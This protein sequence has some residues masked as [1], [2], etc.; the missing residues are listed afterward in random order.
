MMTIMKMMV[1]SMK[2]GGGDDDGGVNCMNKT[3]AFSTCKH[4]SCSRR[5]R[6]LQIQDARRYHAGILEF[7]KTNISLQQ[8]FNRQNPFCFFGCC[9]LR[10]DALR[11][12]G[13]RRGGKHEDHILPIQRCWELMS[14]STGI[15]SSNR[16][17]VSVGITGIVQSSSASA[18]H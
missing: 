14:I 2:N 18:P 12:R 5:R 7:R 3:H 4:F 11:W 13:S 16:I 15:S 6:Q 17:G 9:A 8:P 10:F 1:M